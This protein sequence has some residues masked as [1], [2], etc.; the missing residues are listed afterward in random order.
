MFNFHFKPPLPSVINSTTSSLLLPHKQEFLAQRLLFKT[1]L[2][3]IT[4]CP[5][6]IQRILRHYPIATNN[7]LTLNPTIPGLKTKL[8]WTNVLFKKYSMLKNIIV[9][10]KESVFVTIRIHFYD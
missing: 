8:S 6:I 7:I 9:M 10:L 1:C 5:D 4:L 2:T 3:S